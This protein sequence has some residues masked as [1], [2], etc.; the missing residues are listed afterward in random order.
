MEDYVHK[1]AVSGSVSRLLRTF[2]S[3]NFQGEKVSKPTTLSHWDVCFKG[4]LYIFIFV[5]LKMLRVRI[6][7]LKHLKF[8]IMAKTCMYRAADIFWSWNAIQLA[9]KQNALSHNTPLYLE[10]MVYWGYACDITKSRRHCNY[11]QRV[12]ETLTYWVAAVVKTHK[13]HI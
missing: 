12:A 5:C 7:Y 9:L 3:L 11:T 2:H 10:A 6:F 8:G 13:K 4:I 1:C